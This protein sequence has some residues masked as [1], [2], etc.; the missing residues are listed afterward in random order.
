MN[1]GDEVTLTG[2]IVGVHY[3]AEEIF[4]ADGET[5][6]VEVMPRPSQ[7][8]IRARFMETPDRQVLTISPFVQQK[9]EVDLR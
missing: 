1:V 9:L 6:S 3:E 7:I 4:M 5:R 2:V 8:D